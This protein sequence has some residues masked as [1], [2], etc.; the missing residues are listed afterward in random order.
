[1]PSCQPALAALVALDVAEALAL[2]AADAQVELLDVLVV[3]QVG[4]GP[5]ITMRPLSM[6]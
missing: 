3:R 4:G 5:S 1:L 6:M 2:A